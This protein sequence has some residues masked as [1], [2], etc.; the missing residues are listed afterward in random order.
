MDGMN[1]MPALVS[2]LERAFALRGRVNGRRK[3]SPA[4]KG[5]PNLFS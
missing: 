2:A 1:A 4:R 5:C 3:V